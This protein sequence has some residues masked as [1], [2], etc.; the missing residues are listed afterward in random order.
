MLPQIHVNAIECFCFVLAICIQALFLISHKISAK[1]LLL[2]LAMV[3]PATLLSATS[4]T[5]FLSWDE[6][7]IFYDIIN[8]QSAPLRQWELGAFRTTTTIL[9]PL[10]SAIQNLTGITKDLALVAA[11]AAHWLIGIFLNTLIID[12]IRRLFLK[13]VPRYL[14]HIVLFNAAVLLPVTGLA[15]KTLN[16]DL[17]SMLLGVLGCVWLAAGLQSGG[18]FHLYAS[19]AALTLAAHEKLIASPLLWLCLF[20][21]TARLAYTQTSSSWKELIRKN[22]GYA[23]LTT[24]SSLA[25]IFISFALVHSI[26][27]PNGPDLD[28][29][30]LLMSFQSGFWPI[31]RLFAEKFQH[32]FYFQY[33]APS[34]LILMIV[35]IHLTVSAAA[36]S[37]CLFFRHL[38][39]YIGA[40]QPDL[41]KVA[42][43][44]TILLLTLVIAGIISTFTI[45]TRIWPYIPVADGSY[46]PSSTFN[47]ITLHYQAK[48]LLFHT[49]AST[50]WA[51]AV[52]VN[53]IP[54]VLLAVLLICCVFPIVEKRT[55]VR[56]NTLGLDV[57]AI[58]FM[59][60][61]FVYGLLQIPLYPRY[62]NLFLLGIVITIIPT[63]FTFPIRSLQIKAVLVSV[64]L[65]LLL[66]EVYPFGPLGSTFRPLWSNYSD[67]FHNNPN[68]GKV[69]PWYPGWGEELFEAFKII[70]KQKGSV[71]VRIFHNFPG[72]LIRPPENVTT[73][74]MPIEAGRFRY[75]YGEN[76]YYV[77]SRNG[78][79]TY[80]D[81]GFP[82]KTDPLF[83]IKDRSF[84]K[85]WVFRG[86]DLEASGFRFVRDH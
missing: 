22:L 70:N 30:Q 20:F 69:S 67:D 54:T 16:Y 4:F 64:G 62:F 18:R 51:C 10:L 71:D 73:F 32:L 58:F 27:G 15:L 81:L 84:T 37:T 68:F 19:I 45:N 33:S 63:A 42:I 17:T 85:A 11:K 29:N 50:G 13:R 41:R 55:H 6:C 23:V 44:K 57:L 75:S 59:L 39:H 76:D 74:S 86:S 66:T 12:Q 79:S 35:M 47:G 1:K 26:H 83:T 5:Q 82:H 46:T 7:Y 77:I 61:P 8:F 65:S 24:G 31:K 2:T 25:L 28:P 34:N 72:S 40:H 60:I 78:V 36:F 56:G 49:F 21:A 52:F 43:V 9:G 80:P 38:R 3:T 14:F 48:T 53:A